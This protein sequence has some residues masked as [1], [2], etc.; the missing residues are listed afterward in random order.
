MLVRIWV[1]W[2]PAAQ[3]YL[4]KGLRSV[5]FQA[6][7]DLCWTPGLFQVAACE[8]LHSVVMFMLGKATQMPDGGQGP[9]PLYQLYKRTFPVLLRLACDVDQVSA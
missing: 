5:A 1:G 3:V 2:L 7:L 8:L 6:A 4:F 9:P